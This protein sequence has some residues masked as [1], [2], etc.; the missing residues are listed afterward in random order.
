MLDA[1]VGYETGYF[2]APGAN[3]GGKVHAVY[4]GQPVCGVQMSL[5]A[6][7]FRNAGGIMLELIECAR[8]MRAADVPESCMA[9][10]A[11]LRKVVGDD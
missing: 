2:V 1:R 9:L 10:R 5:G 3:V 11:A 6:D 4:D 8:C 7:F